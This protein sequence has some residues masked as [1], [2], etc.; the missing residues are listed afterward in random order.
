M[1]TKFITN[2]YM[3][4]TVTTTDRVTTS[5]MNLKLNEGMGPNP[6][7]F[8]RQFQKIE[9]VIDAAN[10]NFQDVRLEIKALC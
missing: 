6:I 4:S 9:V 5:F 2:P 1:A 8:I 10:H 3:K 7:P